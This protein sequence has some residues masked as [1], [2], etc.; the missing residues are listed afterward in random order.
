[1]RIGTIAGWVAMALVVAA[2]RQA[3]GYQAATPSAGTQAAA[4]AAAG[5]KLTCTI[6]RRM[7]SEADKAL[8]SRKFADAERLYGEAMAAAPAS[9]EAMAGLVRTTLAE[10]KL[11]EALAMAMK[12]NG[13]HPNDPALLDA[14][15]EVRFRRGEVGEAADAFILSNRLNPCIGVTHY[16]VARFLN[17]SGMYLSSQRQLEVAH[18]LSPQNQEIERRWRFTHAVPRTAEQQLA[19]LKARLENPRPDM[20]EEQKEGIQTAIKGIETRQRGGCELVSP[21]TETKLPIVPISNGPVQM[22]QDMHAAGLDIQFNGK[23]K[24]LEI[25]TGASG[26]MLSRWAAKNAG[27]VPELEIKTGGIG[28]QGPAN[29]FVTHVDDI[30]MGSMEFKNCMVRVLEGGSALQ[31]DGLIGA[32]VFRDYLVTLDIPGREVRIG[33]LP[34]RPDEAAKTT[35]LATSDDLEGPVSIADRAQDRYT[36]PEMKDWT[37]V[38]RM[39]HYLIFPT[40]I[41]NAPVKLFLMDTGASHGMISPAAAREVT[42]VSG[43]ADIRIRGISGEVKNVLTADRVSITFAGVRQITEGMTSYDSSMLAHSSGIEISGLIGFPTLRELV[44]SIDYRDNL[45][46]VVYYPRKG[47]HAH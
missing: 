42:H 27:L 41:G 45:V 7:P 30:K 14:L 4:S 47:F 8:L 13:A 26:I 16:D 33:P 44:I 21:V 1:M 24:R 17:L 28:D 11:P 5:T 31:V 12:F 46:H 18:M 6:D 34:K 9:G 10:D 15:G 38:F 29:A 32:D 35:S 19:M 43:D 25:D 20:T 23:R 37:P 3:A 2:G 39:G 40:V 22:P 36:A